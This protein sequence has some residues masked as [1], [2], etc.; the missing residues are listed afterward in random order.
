MKWVLQ[1]E[2]KRKLNDTHVLFWAEQQFP[3]KLF[4]TLQ[5]Q[6]KC[7][8]HTRTWFPVHM[9]CIFKLCAIKCKLFESRG[10]D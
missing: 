5:L 2:Q 7:N 10:V 9:E 6:Y 3:K 8:L 4:A 1:Y